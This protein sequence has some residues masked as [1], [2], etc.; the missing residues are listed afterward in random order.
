MDIGYEP[1]Q[2]R[3]GNVAAHYW[4]DGCKFTVAVWE[5]SYSAVVL[6]YH[7][8]W[9]ALRHN[10]ECLKNTS[11]VRYF[12]TWPWRK[13]FKLW[14]WSQIGGRVIWIKPFEQAI[15]HTKIGNVT[16]YTYD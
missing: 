5:K 2:C 6:G 11:I 9:W 7:T 8:V 1:K 14:I 12:L 3:C 15:C 4:Q 13:L 10:E 16:F